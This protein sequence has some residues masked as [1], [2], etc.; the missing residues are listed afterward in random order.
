VNF[1]ARS[2]VYCWAHFLVRPDNM[3]ESSRFASWLEEQSTYVKMQ[4]YE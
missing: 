1:S 3:H 2:G 4:A